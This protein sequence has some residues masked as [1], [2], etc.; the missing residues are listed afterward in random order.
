MHRKNTLVSMEKDQNKEQLHI[1]TALKNCGY[2]NC[3]F[4]KVKQDQLSRENKTIKT[5]KKAT[6]DQGHNGLVVIVYVE[7]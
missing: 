6:S 1:R 3:V 5:K 4:E 7:G 2:Q